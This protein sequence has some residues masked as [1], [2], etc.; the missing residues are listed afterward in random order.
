M[1]S[2]RLLGS[3]GPLGSSSQGLMVCSRRVHDL[4]PG[5]AVISI[6]CGSLWS[7][8]TVVGIPVFEPTA[9]E[10]LAST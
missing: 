10:F 9:M 8:L 4:Y 2:A 3:D 7:L 6:A 5:R 1:E